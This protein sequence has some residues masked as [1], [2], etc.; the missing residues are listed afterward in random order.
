MDAAPQSGLPGDGRHDPVPGL[1]FRGV[2]PPG[3]GHGIC[4]APVLLQD[5]AVCHGLIQR[6]D[7]LFGHHSEALVIVAHVLCV[8]EQVDQSGAH[9][10]LDLPAADHRVDEVAVRTDALAHVR[11][12][13][14][15]DVDVAAA[16]QQLL[17]VY[18]LLVCGRNAIEFLPLPGD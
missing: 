15:G 13:M 4:A 14:I 10:L 12:A 6:R 17:Q 1:L 16:L 2:R 8:H 3:D 7:Y 11:P 9:G 18:A 5:D